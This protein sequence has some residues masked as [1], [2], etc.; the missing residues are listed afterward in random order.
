MNKNQKEFLENWVKINSFVGEKE[1]EWTPPVCVHA[2][3]LPVLFE[4]L[5]TIK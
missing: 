3:Q 5:L 1:P 4:I 2:N